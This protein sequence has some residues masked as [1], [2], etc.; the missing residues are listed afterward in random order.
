MNALLERT[1]IFLWILLGVLTPTLSYYGW[2]WY[3]AWKESRKVE[4]RID[5]Q[6]ELGHLNK[7]GIL[8]INEA[9]GIMGIDPINR[10]IYMLD[11]TDTD[12]KNMKFKCKRCE[13]E[14]NVPRY[15]WTSMW[16]GGYGFGRFEKHKIGRWDY[17]L[18]DPESTFYDR[19]TWRG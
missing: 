4:R 16:T 2:N 11:S 9:R 13:K 10:H 19:L 5:F 3:K 15:I 6:N 8:S 1:P 18:G 14:Y 12:D 7:Y 17:C